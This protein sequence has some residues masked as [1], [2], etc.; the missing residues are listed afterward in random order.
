[1]ENNKKCPH[2]GSE[3]TLKAIQSGYASVSPDAAVLSFKSQSLH[4]VI[5][6]DCGTVLRAYVEDPEALVLKNGKNV[7]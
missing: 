5:C 3:R 7:E 2:C 4:Y 1:M 6:R